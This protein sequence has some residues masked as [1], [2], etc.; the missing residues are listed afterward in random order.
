M[1]AAVGGLREMVRVI[2][3]SGAIRLTD[4][5]NR[6]EYVAAFEDMPL[7]DVWLI[8]LS[9]TRHRFLSAVSFGA[10]QPATVFARKI[11]YDAARRAGSI[12]ASA[13]RPML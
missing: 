5:V 9:P 7:A 10:F 12:S 6:Y 2:R 3:R 8:V 11:A 4:I 1:W 13:W